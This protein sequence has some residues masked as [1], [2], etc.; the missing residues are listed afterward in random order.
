MTRPTELSN[1]LIELQ[2]LFTNAAAIIE[3]LSDDARDALLNYHSDDTN[4]IH[5]IRWGENNSNELIDHLNEGHAAFILK[6]G[7]LS[8]EVIDLPFKAEEFPSSSDDRFSTETIYVNEYVDSIES[9][10][11]GEDYVRIITNALGDATHT[12]DEIEKM[13]IELWSTCEWQAP[14]TLIDELGIEFFTQDHPKLVIRSAREQGY[15]AND[16]GWVL[17]VE[18]ATKYSSINP[19]SPETLSGMACGDAEIISETEAEDFDDD[20]GLDINN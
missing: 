10:Y 3:T 5:V 1:A 13:A 7:Q 12:K 6:D 14:E 9:H 11:T 18:S 17:D 16:D 4:L 15:W 20:N 8:L 2:V 19:P